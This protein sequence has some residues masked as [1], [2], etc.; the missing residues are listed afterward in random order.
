MDNRR[1]L[2]IGLDEPEYLELKSRV[3]MPTLYHD[4][5]PR[6]QVDGKQL[7]AEHRDGFGRFV[8]V[9]HVVFHGIFENDLPAIHALALWSGPCFPS[10]RGMMDARQ[11]LPCLIRALEVTQFG[12]DLRGFADAGTAVN[13]SEP[14]VAKW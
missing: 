6:L 3:N 5:L 8:P 9:S 14:S 13:R 10:A 11:R 12:G 4:M 1:L 2:L 7:F